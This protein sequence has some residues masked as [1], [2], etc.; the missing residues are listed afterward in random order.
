MLYSQL[1]LLEEY[2]CSE[3][4]LRNQLSIILICLKLY[5]EEYACV[6]FCVSNK[7]GEAYGNHFPSF[8]IKSWSM[9]M[10]VEI[11]NSQPQTHLLE[12]MPGCQDAGLAARDLPI[13]RQTAVMLVQT[14]SSSLELPQCGFLLKKIIILKKEIGICFLPHV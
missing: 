12:Q 14:G 11:T 2:L 8:P 7:C 10:G 13:G 6:S 3:S 5:N 4:N 1:G 9:N